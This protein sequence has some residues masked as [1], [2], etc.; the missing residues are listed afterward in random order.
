M[1]AET[2]LIIVTDLDA[3][4]LDHTYTW[5]A[6]RPALAK[7]KA[8]DVPLVLN[9]SKTVA[10]M[11]DLAGELGTKAPV[12]A[13]NGGILAIPD[14]M[15]SE[16]SA[17]RSGEYT[18]QTT[19]LSRDH[20]LAVAHE[21]RAKEGYGFSG[22]SDWTAEEVADRTG[23]PLPKARRSQSRFATEPIL[24]NDSEVRRREFEEKLA[25]KGIR[26]LRGGRFLHLMGPADK[27]D[28]LKSVRELYENLFPSTKWQV[29]A[30]GDSANDKA[31]LEAA[32]I[33]VVI[34]HEDGPHI[35]PESKN[36]IHA[37]SPATQGWNDAILKI[38]YETN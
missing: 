30:L 26:I 28:G 17:D 18:I 14:G 24:W 27:A 10:E 8:M 31:M 9:S 4:L 11:K 35:E 29:V 36:V 21:L 5:S 13:E 25:E 32:D 23:L 15:S 2:K 7:M 34:P 6:A 33:A 22:F 37:S 16:R 19:G 12:I 3:T 1:A 20:I 38:L